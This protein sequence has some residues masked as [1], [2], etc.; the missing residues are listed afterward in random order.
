MRSF[1]DELR[2]FFRKGDM[3]LLILCMI[4]TAFGCLVIV[5]ATYAYGFTRFLI[6]QLAGAFIGIFLYVFISSIDVAF[7]SEHRMALVLFNT[8]LLALLIPF[9]QTINGN[10]SWIHFPGFPMNIQPAEICKVTFVLI[11]ASVMAS[12]Q[13]KPSAIP[14]VM[15]LLFHL[16]FLFGLSFVLSRDAGVSLIFVFIFAGIAF[17]GG[18]SLLWFLAGGAS[19]AVVA[20]IIWTKVFDEYQQKRFLILVDPTIDPNGINERYHTRLSLESL[21]GGGFAGQGLFNGNRTQADALPAQHTDYI[22]STIGEEL[23]FMGCLIVVL[24]MFAIIARCIYVGNRSNDYMRRLVCYGAAS[25][26]I[27]QVFSNIG[28]CI[29]VTPVIGL[30]LPFISYGG[31]SIVTMFMAMG[32]VSGIHMRPAPDASAR[33]IRPRQA[34]I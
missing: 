4:T 31:S 24:L 17:A 5:S 1:F 25:A 34:A 29:G 16:V 8:F 30:T 27:F 7:F 23:G 9:G 21:T 14:S 22:F 19:L 10:R 20:P 11:C 6:L 33:Y 18:I 26:L 13:N 15:H 32:V 12:H 2:G 28:M 3:V